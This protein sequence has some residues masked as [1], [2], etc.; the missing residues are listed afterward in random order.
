MESIIEIPAELILMETLHGLAVLARQT[1]ISIDTSDKRLRH[2][3]LRLIGGMDEDTRLPAVKAYAQLYGQESTELMHALLFDGDRSVVQAACYEVLWKPSLVDYRKPDTSTVAKALSVASADTL[4]GSFMMMEDLPRENLP[5]EALRE[6]LESEAPASRLGAALLLAKG[7]DPQCVPVLLQ[8]LSSSDEDQRWAVID[9]LGECGDRRV[10]DEIWKVYNEEPGYWDAAARALFRLGEL[11]VSDLLR[12]KQEHIPGDTDNNFDSACYQLLDGL[13]GED[14]LEALLDQLDA[15]GAI[16]YGYLLGD[17]TSY[18]DPRVLELCLKNGVRPVEG[19]PQKEID[20]LQKSSDPRVIRVFLQAARSDGA[21]AFTIG[22][23]LEGFDY[24]ISRHLGNRHRSI[25]LL[26]E[27][28]GYGMREALLEG[29][30]RNELIDCL[31][32]WFLYFEDD[33]TASYPAGRY[34]LLRMLVLLGF[35]DTELLLDALKDD[36]EDI[37]FLAACH[38]SRNGSRAGVNALLSILSG[39][40]DDESIWRFWALALNLIKSGNQVSPDDLRPCFVGDCEKTRLAAVIVLGHIEDD[41]STELLVEAA[42]DPSP[43]V[44]SLSARYLAGKE[45]T[46]SIET[47]CSLLR[48][49][50]EHPRYRAVEAIGK[51]GDLS[52]AP[53]IIPL[54]A[55]DSIHVREAA[56]GVLTDW[57]ADCQEEGIRH[58]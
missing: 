49:E 34:G 35:N 29:P 42:H 17:L 5:C 26:H 28:E 30:D 23:V 33:T 46:G 14:L 12:L 18:E 11:S 20:Y 31:K 40:F 13:H 32:N 25:S 9:A 10:V 43:W 2:Y 47:L 45:G 8:A 55:D 21:D 6:L 37:R 44:R 15:P 7:R 52:Y 58:L 27:Q 51:R 16:P 3:L 22:R 48:D 50:S 24:L 57:V 54:L 4:E 36:D 53:G 56:Q 38:M 1:D 39:M 41:T 19:Y